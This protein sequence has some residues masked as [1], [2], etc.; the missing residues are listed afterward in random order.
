MGF[1][2]TDNIRGTKT[3]IPKIGIAT[4]TK[5]WQDYVQNLPNYPGNFEGRGIVMSG[6]G[7][8]YFT[9]AWIS[10]SILRKKGCELPIE[11]WYTTGEL[12]EDAFEE[13]SKLNVQC[14]NINDFENSLPSGFSIKPFAILHSR[15]EEILFLDAD[16]IVV[17]N[18]S[19]LFDDIKYLKWG[20]IFWPD[21][22]ETS[23]DNPIWEILKVNNFSTREQESG[24]LLINKSKCWEELN[25]CAYF[26]RWG[27]IYYTLLYG[28]KDTFR[29]AWLALNKRFYM[30]NKMVGSCGYIDNGQYF[31]TTMVQH[32]SNS[33][34]LF[35]HRNLLKWDI[36]LDNEKTWIVF[37][38]F[39]DQGTSKQDYRIDKNA[40]HLYVDLIG[41]T[42]YKDF[43]DL[44]PWIETECLE[45]LMNFRAT[46]LYL[47]ML[48][49][50]YFFQNGRLK[51]LW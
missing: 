42:Y 5:D 14:R 44:F 1:F 35:L 48:Q 39:S 38:V 43:E 8:K 9:C 50:D 15:F 18:P 4:L 16:N 3:I 19:Y 49:R 33:E 13:C 51:K 23:L 29:F 34:V 10:I 27:K 7:F 28:D 21:F 36:T 30:I 46:P 31:G 37:K 17:K 11:L 40:F 47:A 41:D 45:I 2:Y 25:L 12:Y 20:S 6:G 24:Q 32:D 22:W 26:N